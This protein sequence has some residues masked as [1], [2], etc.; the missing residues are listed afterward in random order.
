MLYRWLTVAAILVALGGSADGAPVLFDFTASWCGPCQQMKPIVQNIANAGYDVRVVD[1]SNGMPTGWEPYKSEVTAYPT[2]LVIE[3]NTLIGRITGM[4]SEQQLLA[5]LNQGPKLQ[6]RT[7]RVPP[8][9]CRVRNHV[10]GAYYMGSGTLVERNGATALVVTAA[11]TFTQEAGAGELSVAFPNGETLAAKMIEL[12]RPHDL[13]VLEIAAPNVQPIPI[14][15]SDPRIGEMLL[16]SGYGEQGRYLVN[17]GALAEFVTANNVRGFFSIHGPAR[18]GDSGGPVLNERGELVGVVQSTT[19]EKNDDGTMNPARMVTACSCT[20]IRDLLERIRARHR[21]P[22]PQN[23]TK[24]GTIEVRPDVPPVGTTPV[25]PLPD[26]SAGPLVPV[27]PG[28]PDITIPIPAGPPAGVAQ[29]GGN[30][31]AQT[32]STS[33]SNGGIVDRIEGKVE[34]VATKAATSWIEGLLIAVGIGSGP[35]GVVAGVGGALAVNFISKKLKGWWANR[36]SGGKT[37]APSVPITWNI[38]PF[39]ETPLAR[40][41]EPLKQNTALADSLRAENER[42]LAELAKAQQPVL[43]RQ[44]AIGDKLPDF[45]RAIQA[46]TDANPQLRHAAKFFEDTY[47]VQLSGD[48]SHA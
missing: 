48:L 35:A 30:P 38:P 15:Q 26:E 22:Q 47:K 8:A 11:H 4:A 28:A 34:G 5:L 36:K 14:G 41:A 44:P 45:R 25:K 10:A 6:Q 19:P 21:Q 33:P 17:R 29:S 43:Y 27:T 9:V 37:D 20:P 2:F 7:D 18:H 23:G 12:D 46:A 42:L 32:N 1:C 40:P 31:P 39:T 16:S 13:A 24:P 3:G